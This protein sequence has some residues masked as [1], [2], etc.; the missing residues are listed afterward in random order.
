M[1]RQRLSASRKEPYSV[2]VMMPVEMVKALD[3]LRGEMQA[4]TKGRVVS[5]S[6][7][8]RAC[9]ASVT[10]KANFGNVFEEEAITS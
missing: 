10:G 7:A 8:I 3:E 6:E 5:R 2:G 4:R 1:A 9:I